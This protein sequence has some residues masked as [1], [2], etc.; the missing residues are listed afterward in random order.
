MIG[1]SV[2]TAYL[3]ATLND[4]LARAWTSDT[5]YTAGLL[6]DLGRILIASH[7]PGGAGS[8]Y[9]SAPSVTTESEEQLI[10]LEQMAFGYDHTVDPLGWILQQPHYD[11]DL[12]DY[13][14][15]HRKV[16]IWEREPGT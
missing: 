16:E 11:P 12:Q 2:A 15:D 5:V 8:V 4:C 7:E 14:H 6:H 1:H 3:A 10:D 9:G 13:R